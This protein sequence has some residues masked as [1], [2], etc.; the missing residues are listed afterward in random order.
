MTKVSDILG[1]MREVGTWVDWDN[2][3][4]GVIVGSEDAE[5]RQAAVAW[6]PSYEAL[7][8]AIEL[9]CQLFIA[10]EPTFYT[11][12]HELD[13]IGEWP[14]A[15]QKKRFIE[16]SGL[17]V[18]RN[19]DTWDNM[20]E[21]GIPWSWA[22]FLKVE[23]E[24]SATRPYLNVYPIPETTLD[25]LARKVAA[26]TALIGEPCVEVAGDP[27]MRVTHLGIGT[28]ADAAREPTARWERT[29]ASSATTGPITGR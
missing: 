7:R 19:H 5:V 23:G 1:H 20:P 8:E 24:P 11:H 4:D 9:G 28:G 27:G 22:R 16:Q 6:M 12:R 3:V 17:T 29:R 13:H 2:T 25:E 10:H 14:G 18:L 21:V 15:D 26:R